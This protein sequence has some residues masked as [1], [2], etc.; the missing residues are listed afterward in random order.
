MAE[1]DPEN[2]PRL[3]K[4]VEADL[5][6][7]RRLFWSPDSKTLA[8]FSGNEFILMDGLTLQRIANLSPDGDNVFMDY[9]PAMGVAALSPNREDVELRAASTGELLNAI[10]PGAPFNNISFS[11]DGS[12]LSVASMDEWAVGLWETGSGNLRQTLR[13]FETAAP[14]YSAAFAGSKYL[15]YIARATAQMQDIASGSMLPA[16][17]HEEFIG[18]TD[19]ST[20]LDL[21]ATGAAGTYE[22]TYSGLV[23]L[24]EPKTGQARSVFRSDDRVSSALSFSPNGRLLAGTA[25]E[26]ILV[27]DLEGRS[28]AASFHGHTESVAELAFSPDGRSLASAGYVDGKVRLWRVLP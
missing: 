5:P 24:W 16:V 14:V 7:C 6:N 21:L 25:G 23:T 27:W 15:L 26:D 11:P 12:L 3:Q 22:D 28:L 19:Y 1:I 17:F 10:H 8:T 13:G 20:M 2:A 9:S 18:S 4:A